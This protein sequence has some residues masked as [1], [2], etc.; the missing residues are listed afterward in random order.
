MSK[1][2]IRSQLSYMNR[3]DVHKMLINEYVLKNPGDT[4]FL[5][6]DTSKDKRDFDVIRENHKFLWDESDSTES[7]GQRFAKKYYD[8][9][10]KEY[11]IGDLS[12]YKE[13]KI[14]LRWRTQQEVVV[15]RGQFSCGNKKCEERDDLKT[16]EVNFGYVEDSVK[17]N[18]LVKIRLCEPCSKKL[19]YHTKKKEV[20][21]LKKH[22]KRRSSGEKKKDIAEVEKVAESE[23]IKEAQTSE[24]S[25][26]W[27]NVKQTDVKSREE[28]MEEYLEDLLL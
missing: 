22:V 13:N 2:S 12:R 8:K 21:R 26:P 28:E 23:V 9:L 20:K 14:A 24:E 25:S 19:N 15:G 10:F 18:A 17:K 6:R 4:K 11:C 5:Q 1:M 27:A 16:W 3:Y 7:W